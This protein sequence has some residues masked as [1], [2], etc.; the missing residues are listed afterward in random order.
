M[1]A[2]A[3]LRADADA[4]QRLLTRLTTARGNKVRRLVDPLLHR[5]LIL[6]LAEL[7]ANHTDHDVLVLG[8]KLERLEAAGALGVVLKVKSVDVEV[9]EQLLGNDVVRA[10]GEVAAADEVAAAQVDTRVHVGGDL[11]ETVIVQL[12]VCVEEVI[13]GA[14]VILVLLPALAEGLGAEVGHA[15]VIE[16]NVAQ[17]SLVQRI[18][19]RLVH[20]GNSLE[21]LGI[22]GVRLRCVSLTLLVAHMEPRGSD[23]SQLDVAPFLFG[24]RVLDQLQPAMTESPGITLR[25]FSMRLTTSGWYSLNIEASASWRRMVPGDFHQYVAFSHKKSRQ[26]QDTFE[27]IPHQTPEAGAVVLAR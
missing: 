27:L 11:A 16:L 1:S 19:L 21:V 6:Q 9:L 10:L 15:R 24:G 12:D 4:L 5:L 25:S 17:A 8:Q 7:G 26:E 14:D 20:L 2:K 22:I 13:D 23:H 18:Q 3:T